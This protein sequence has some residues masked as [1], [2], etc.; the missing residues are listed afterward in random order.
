M[1]FLDPQVLKE[2]EER[3][4]E[5][6]ME[7]VHRLVDALIVYGQTYGDIPINKPAD[8]VAFYID[9]E[10]RS[11]TQALEVVNPKLASQWRRKFERDA[12]ELMGLHNG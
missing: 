9:L 11:V 2:L 6:C 7:I 5:E 4:V 12:A 1:N 8:F 10:Q 3:T